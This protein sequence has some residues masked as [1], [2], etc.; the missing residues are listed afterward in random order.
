MNIARH[1]NGG[2]IPATVVGSGTLRPV[3][4]RADQGVHFGFVEPFATMGGRFKHLQMGMGRDA[5]VAAWHKGTF[6]VAGELWNDHAVV[7]PK[8]AG[9]PQLNAFVAT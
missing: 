6:T 7:I 2:G 9:T 8:V 3:Q 1:P 5:V 4:L